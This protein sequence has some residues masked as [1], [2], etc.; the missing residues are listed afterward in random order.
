VLSTISIRLI[1]LVACWTIVAAGS[2][3]AQT[4]ETLA[5]V[6]KIYVDSLGNKPGADRL[7]EQLVNRLRKSHSFTVVSSSDQADA[8]FTGSGEV[9][10]KGYFSLNPRVRSP[11]S[12]AQPVYG[13]FLSVELKGARNETLWSYLV[14]PHRLWSGDV[15][16]DLAGHVVS[17]LV[18]AV[19]S[20]RGK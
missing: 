18:E 12:G 6:H 15:G 2:G 9:W 7:R 14:T 8:V 10:I 13:G 16:Q 5:Q 1:S 4:A 19:A 11:E 20:E 17:K 3:I